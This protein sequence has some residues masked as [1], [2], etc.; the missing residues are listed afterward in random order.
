ME[1]MRLDK[2][3]AAYTDKSRKEAK[4]LIRNGKVTVDGDVCQ[5]EDDKVTRSQCIC[6]QGERIQAEAYVY[7]MLNKPAGVVSAT[8][9][10]K[11][12]TV[13]ELIENT[14]REVFPVGRLDKD[15]EGLLFLTDDGALS[16]RLLS[17]KYHVEK[18]YEVTYEGTLLQEAKERFLTGIDIGEKQLTKPAGLCVPTPGRAIVTLS[19]GRFHQVKR[20]IA[21]VG[22][23]VTYLK[24][25]RMAGIELDPALTNGAW[26]RLKQEEIS[27][28]Y[29]QAGMKKGGESCQSKSFTQ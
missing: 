24:R 5:K 19:E 17:P 1:K 13:V 25:I 20:M 27:M 18:V 22:G 8:K 4:N 2:Y 16:H 29:E 15:T 26:R 12:R 6:L 21:A 9:D 10:A 23:K 3:V 14:G 28:L 7:Y 11:E